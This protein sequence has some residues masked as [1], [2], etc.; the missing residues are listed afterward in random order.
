MRW[1]L[2][3]LVAAAC[4]KAGDKPADVSLGSLVPKTAA[5]IL[6]Y[7]PTSLPIVTLLR[8]FTKGTRCWGDLERKVVD[9][10]QITL[11]R[12]DS[13]FIIEADIP[14]VDVESCAKDAFDTDNLRIHHEAGLVG[15]ELPGVGTGWAAW[16]GR[17][18]IAGSKPAVLEALAGPAIG[19]PWTARITTLATQP[20]AEMASITTGEVFAG[21]LEIEVA[22]WELTLNSNRDP[23]ASKRSNGK[24]IIH[25]TTPSQATA[26]ARRIATG[27]LHFIVPLPD[28]VIA[29][30]RKLKV[31]VRGADIEVSFDQSMFEGMD[32]GQLGQFYEQMKLALPT[33]PS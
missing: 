28:T 12:P 10:Y 32:L 13:V 18:V 20:L 8:T 1:F 29:A 6:R 23:D 33:P 31:D 27:D 11:A 15:F 5:G 25:A 30:I 7:A 22:T 19:S 26:G 3:A 9:S 4:S 17:Y 14:I 16:R 24:V 21:L 2:V